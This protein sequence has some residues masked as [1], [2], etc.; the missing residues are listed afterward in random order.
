MPPPPP[1]LPRVQMVF[2]AIWS[3]M[4]GQGGNV[5][6]VDQMVLKAPSEVGK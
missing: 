4:Q 2:K 1:A 3:E 6:A 5:H